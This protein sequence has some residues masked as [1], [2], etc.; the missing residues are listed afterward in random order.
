MPIILFVCL[1]HFRNSIVIPCRTR[2]VMAI[3]CSSIIQEAEAFSSL[4][5]WLT[6]LLSRYP[7]KTLVSGPML[8]LSLHYNPLL[9]EVDQGNKRTPPRF[10]GREAIVTTQCLN[11][12][13]VMF[14]L[15]RLII[16]TKGF[17]N[18]GHCQFNLNVI[19]FPCFKQSHVNALIHMMVISNAFL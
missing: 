18:H 14:P 4:L 1:S 3:Q 19:Y 11:G 13:W 9:E 15:C 7:L 5:L 2:V 16:T 12:W 6:G 17:S 8:L 10:V